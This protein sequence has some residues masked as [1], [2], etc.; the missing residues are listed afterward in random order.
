MHDIRGREV[1]AGDLIRIPHYVDR[2]TKRKCYMYKLVVGIT[3][4]RIIS[5]HG[6]LVACV[7]VTDIW[8][9]KSLDKAHQCPLSVCEEFEIIDGLS[10]TKATG[11][12]ETWYE[13]P[14]VKEPMLTPPT[15]PS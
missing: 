14:K 3:S 10:E 12:L 11:E 9:K 1:K 8:E 7:D 4:D 13:R 2:R 5:E 6:D 15:D